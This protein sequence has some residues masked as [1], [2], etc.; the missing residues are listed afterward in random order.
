MT[1]VCVYA[2]GNFEPGDEVLV[3]DGAVFDTGYFK[4]KA[5]APKKADAKIDK[6]SSR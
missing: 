5:D 1:L 6:E 4:E 2:F 3:P